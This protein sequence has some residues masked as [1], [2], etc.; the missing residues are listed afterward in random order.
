MQPWKL[1]AIHKLQSEP[2]FGSRRVQLPDDVIERIFNEKLKGGYRRD[3]NKKCPSC[4]I[5]MS[6]TGECGYCD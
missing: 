1:R 6:N 4:G 2:Q 3:R 5:L